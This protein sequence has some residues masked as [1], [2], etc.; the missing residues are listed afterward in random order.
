ME[1]LLIYDAHFN[2]LDQDN[3]YSSKLK[4]H[5]VNKTFTIG[6]WCSI[7]LDIILM[8]IS[9]IVAYKV[10]RNGNW[11]MKSVPLFM[12][13]IQIGNVTMTF[14]IIYKGLLSLWSHIIA[15]ICR[16]ACLGLTEYIMWGYVYYYWVAS[17][18]VEIVYDNRRV[19]YSDL[20]I[21]EKENKL[22]PS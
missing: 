2:E 14:L 9:S 12:T 18:N 15:S 4:K 21:K 11:L 10:F 22:K 3:V 7:G 13:I 20:P 16:A 6:S 8:C 19:M 5:F 17:Q 1:L